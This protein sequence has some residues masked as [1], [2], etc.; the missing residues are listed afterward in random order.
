[1]NIKRVQ[2]EVLSP[3]ITFACYEKQDTLIRTYF[4]KDNLILFV[5]VTIYIQQ[6][7]EIFG[8]CHPELDVFATDLSHELLLSKFIKVIEERNADYK[9]SSLLHIY[10]QKMWHDHA[11]I[12]GN[13]RALTELRAAIDH[14]ILYGKGR[15]GTFSSDGEGYELFFSCLLGETENNQDWQDIRLPYHDKDVYVPSEKEVDPFSHLKFYRN[16]LRLE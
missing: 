16:L 5:E 1:M 12:V 7:E 11:I 3:T 10:A 9:E 15:V 14:A 6:F 4:F 2:Y 8:Q 13:K